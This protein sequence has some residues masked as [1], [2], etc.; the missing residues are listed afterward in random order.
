MDPGMGHVF[1]VHGDLR[2]LYCDAWLLPCGEQ[3]WPF[4]HWLEWPLGAV[5][6]AGRAAP[7]RGWHPEGRRVMKLAGWPASYPQPFVTNVGLDKLR[8][9]GWFIE[10]AVQFVEEAVRDL[11][12]RGARPV[13]RA[14]PLL[15]LPVVGT[16]YGGAG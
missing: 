10:G 13:P 1:V 11:K 4:A 15:A 7:P 14:R 8:P 12:E 3:P 5:A 16:G 2:K 6:A 9:L